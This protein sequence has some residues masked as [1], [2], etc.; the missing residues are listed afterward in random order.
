MKFRQPTKIKHVMPL[1][2]LLSTSLPSLTFS[3]GN[4]SILSKQDLQKFNPQFNNAA[5]QFAV[6]TEMT[7]EEYFKQGND[8]FVK[9]KF[10]SAI[11]S[12]RQ[13]IRLQSNSK[14]V[15]FNLSLALTKLKQFDA[16]IV[17]I[18][19]SID[20]DPTYARAHMLLGTIYQEQGAINLARTT[21][22]KVNQLEPTN[23]E[24]TFALARLERSQNNLKQAAQWY[25]S[26]VTLLPS[27]LDG[28]FELGFTLST[29]GDQEGARNAYEQAVKI[30][31]NC[32]DAVCNLAHTLRILGDMAAAESHYE[33]IVAAWP[34]H[35][36]A[37][38]GYAETL[39][40]LG[41]LE[42]GFKHF[43]WRWKR[44][45]D[46]RNFAEK[47]WDG[48][49]PRGKRIILRAE[50][51]QGDTLQFIRYARMLK[52]QGA[53]VIVEAQD[54]LV[55]L[56]SM[57]PYIDQVVPVFSQLPQHDAQI[58]L[59][60]LPRIYHTTLETVP[61]NIPYL[62]ADEKLVDAW[63]K[64]LSNDKN[65]KIGICWEGSPYYD[66]MRNPLSRKAIPLAAFEPLT[67]IPG[68]SVYSL[69]KMNGTDQLNHLN[70]T[71]RIHDFGQDF[72]YHNGRF[73]DTAAFIMNAD[74]IITVDTSVAHLAGA[75]GKRVWMI[76]PAIADWRWLQDR[77]D[78]HWYPTM[79]IFRAP[80]ITNGNEKA[81]DWNAVIRTICRE[82][83]LL[84]N[85]QQQ[86]DIVTAEISV[87]ELIDKI[88]ILEIKMANIT[89]QAKLRNIK[90]ELDSL[91]N[92]LNTYIPQSVQLSELSKKLLTVNKQLWDIEDLIRDK[93]RSKEFD[94]QFID[95]ARKVYITNDVR[96]A[97]KRQINDLLGSRLVEE[98]SYKAY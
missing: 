31:P 36:G 14:Q 41:K 55:Q 10:E 75:M 71:M 16:A 19:R 81:S 53:Y 46:Y 70:A 76:V 83:E 23:P 68:I 20:L 51:G 72:D 60:S 18:N 34:S 84:S 93:E 64:R 3:G 58:P 47:L 86:P 63:S 27:S 85:K 15:F 13:A 7:Y 56:L 29:I 22:E 26:A 28:W 82:L 48:S 38:Y 54:T 74:L 62:Y 50:Y 88:T 4:I 95:L 30:N 44:D 33:R 92:T 21:Y 87:G 78:S 2:L 6:N 17:E 37:H 80:V 90:T 57:C 65:L 59:M 67:H 89:N 45:H 98:K 61:T 12:Y 1:T 35:A 52:D 91:T 73:M 24:V 66:T 11:N 9:G 8:F 79:K 25:K 97:I 77:E 43:E 40:T 49:D 96:C 32:L 5:Q 39:L 42:E 69:Q 94:H